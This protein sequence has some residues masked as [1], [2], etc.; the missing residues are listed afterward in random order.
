MN[1]LGTGLVNKESG[2]CLN[3]RAFSG[4]MR[5]ADRFCKMAVSA[6][7]DAIKDNQSK[8]IAQNTGIILA[9]AFGP[10]PTTFKFLDNLLDYKENEVSPTLFSHSVH[11]AAVSYIA[12]EFQ[13]NGPT[14]TLA[15]FDGVFV[16]AL[17][18]ARCW[19]E[20]KVCSYVLLGAAEERGPVF[21]KVFDITEGSIFF[22]LN[23]EEGFCR[24]KLDQRQGAFPEQGRDGAVVA[25]RALFDAAA[26][27]KFGNAA[28]AECIIRDCQAYSA[29]IKLFH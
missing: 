7:Q 26:K 20:N 5:R 8:V 27:I 24:L 22:L 17:K 29:V 23:Q 13:I 15:G 2:D 12:A 19:L 11:N 14:L 1:I 25:A 6:A 9:T 3:G 21:D 4:Q 18:L 16:E 28:E 10:H